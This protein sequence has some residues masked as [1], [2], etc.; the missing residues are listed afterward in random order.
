METRNYKKILGVDVKIDYN[1]TVETD[2]FDFYEEDDP[3]K[4]IITS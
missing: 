4:E 1:P 2:V 3:F